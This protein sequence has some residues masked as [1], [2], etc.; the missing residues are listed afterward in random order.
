MLACLN[1]SAGSGPEEFESN[2][3]ETFNIFV[4]DQWANAVSNHEKLVKNKKHESHEKKGMNRYAVLKARVFFSYAV[5]F[6][7]EN[8]QAFIDNSCHLKNVR[9]AP[10]N[11]TS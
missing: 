3:H 11:I 7:L 2:C 8:T 10:D 5:C 1:G 4:R 9:L 6:L